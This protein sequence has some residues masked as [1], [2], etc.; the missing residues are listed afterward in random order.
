MGRL[1]N[2][3]RSLAPGDDR[4][5]AK[6]LSAQRSASHRNRGAGR[7]ADDGQAWEDNDRKQDRRGTWY[8]P[9]R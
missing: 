9:A 6:D 1:G 3:V 2:F 7:A 8:R 4:Q 5:L